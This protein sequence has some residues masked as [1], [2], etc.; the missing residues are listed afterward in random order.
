[1]WQKSG[2]QILEQTSLRRAE[3]G[4]ISKDEETLLDQN[5]QIKPPALPADPKKPPVIIAP[6]L[7]GKQ[8]G[9]AIPVSQTCSMTIIA[10]GEVTQEG[11]GRLVEYINLI[12]TWFPQAESVANKIN[13]E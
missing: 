11:L 8:V 2:K 7:N 6:L 9:S 12:K 13:C 3:N 4:D 10:D 5:T 1:M